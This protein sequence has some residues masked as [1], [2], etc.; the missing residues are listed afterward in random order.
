MISPDKVEQTREPYQLPE[1][2]ASATIHF[3][4]GISEPTRPASVHAYL[5]ERRYALIADLIAEGLTS[6]QIEEAVNNGQV[7][8]APV[9]KSRTTDLF[10]IPEAEGG[11][12]EL[13][14][15]AYANAGG[16]G[17]DPNAPVGADIVSLGGTLES[18][19]L[20][21][22]ALSYA[23]HKGM[24]IET[25]IDR[26]MGVGNLFVSKDGPLARM[27]GLTEPTASNPQ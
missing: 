3:G 21:L 8:T 23:A 20:A 11:L 6:Q 10:W 1:R 22:V 26:G 9:F 18:Q 15:A 5:E 14:A 4:Y 12:E 27:L 24:V 2:F 17:S 25:D 13:A 16:D 19:Q 7:K